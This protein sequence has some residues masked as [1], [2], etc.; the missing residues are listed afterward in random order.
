MAKEKVSNANQERNIYSFRRVVSELLPV[1]DVKVETAEADVKSLCIRASKPKAA[2]VVRAD[3]GALP[4]RSGV[5][6][7]HLHEGEN[8]CANASSQYRFKAN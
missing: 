8:E 1:L 2:E 7:E 5:F 3:R 4:E 6:E